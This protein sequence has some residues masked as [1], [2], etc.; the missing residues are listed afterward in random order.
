MKN[1]KVIW[2][3]RYKKK[4]NKQKPKDILKDHEVFYLKLDEIEVSLKSYWKLS[5]TDL[6]DYNELKPRKP[7]KTV[8]LH[9]LK[10]CQIKSEQTKNEDDREKYRILIKLARVDDDQIIP[11][12]CLYWLK[13]CFTVIKSL[14]SNIELL[15][16]FMQMMKIHHYECEHTLEAVYKSAKL[17]ILGLAEQNYEIVREESDISPMIDEKGSNLITRREV[18]E[19]LN[20]YLNSTYYVSAK[21]TYKINQLFYY[22]FLH[23]N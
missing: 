6:F 14:T 21:L 10:S 16:R 19:M 11:I 1:A 20:T 2:L 7:Y 15:H 5:N 22:D 17:F 12:E 13:K 9:L 23:N 8:L 18:S 3:K 4:K